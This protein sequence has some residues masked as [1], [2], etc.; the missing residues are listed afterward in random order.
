MKK[1][2]LT[3]PLLIALSSQMISAAD[4][5][6]AMRARAEKAIQSCEKSYQDTKNQ[7]DRLN[8]VKKP[9]IFASKKMKMDYENLLN[10]LPLNLKTFDINFSEFTK[11]TN[12][13]I[14]IRTAKTVEKLQEAIAAYSSNCTRFSSGLSKF[15]EW[16]RTGEG[17]AG[18]Y[19]SIF[20]DWQKDAEK[21]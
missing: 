1:V 20:R 18:G 15:V 4:V 9:N 10:R 14:G 7:R 8:N 19:E 2:F 21:N 13:K 16:A 6:P 5:T 17:K 3:I 12:E 11:F